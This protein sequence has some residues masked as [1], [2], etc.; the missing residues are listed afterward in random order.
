[1]PKVSKPWRYDWRKDAR[2]ERK[3][4]TES[5]ARVVMEIEDYINEYP[6]GNNRIKSLQK[7]VNYIIYRYT[8]HCDPVIQVLYSANEKE[9]HITMLEYREVVIPY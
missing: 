6:C 2:E 9:K 1:M 5:H 8:H 4:L 3:Q 7:D